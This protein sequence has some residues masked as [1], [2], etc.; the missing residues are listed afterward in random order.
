MVIG[1]AC[2]GGIAR[3]RV[4]V[5]DTDSSGAACVG[6]GNRCVGCIQGIDS[7]AFGRTALLAATVIGQRRRRRTSGMVDYRQICP[8]GVIGLS[9]LHLPLV[10][11]SY[12]AAYLFIS[13][14]G[15]VGMLRDML[16][17]LG[18]TRLPSV[19]GFFGAFVVLT[20]LSYPYILLSVRVALPS[21]GSVIGRSS[22]Q[23]RLH[24]T[25]GVLARHT[26]AFTSRHRRWRFADRPLC[27]RD[28]R[29]CLHAALQYVHA[30]FSCN[31]NR[32]RA[33]RRWR[34]CRWCWSP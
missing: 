2:P 29:C 34:C 33:G 9:P 4:D 13:I 31:I 23:P 26:A 3:L 20:L 30:L 1:A 12:V 7:W 32:F 5:V 27:L 6:T 24:A 28:F 10:L 21:T 17:P 19:Y 14:F 11:P 16:V 22:T 18:I 15:P 8:D 25:T